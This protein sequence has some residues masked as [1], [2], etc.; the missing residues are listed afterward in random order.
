VILTGCGAACP[1]STAPSLDPL[2]GCAESGKRPSHG[3]TRRGGVEGWPREQRPSCN[4]R[5]NKPKP[6]RTTGSPERNI[7]VAGGG[8]MCCDDSL[9]VRVI[10]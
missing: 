3:S 9:T 5:I 2:H 1:L 8:I 6:R 7:G 4:R 10:P